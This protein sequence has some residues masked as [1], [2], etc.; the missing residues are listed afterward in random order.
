MDEALE[1]PIW[2]ALT[3]PQASHGRR[4]GDAACFARDVAPFAAIA[5]PH[6]RAYDDLARL[7]GDAPEA[8]LFRPL[9]EAVPEGWRATSEREIVQMVCEALPAPRR[10][11]P[12]PCIMPLGDADIPAMLDLAAVTHPGPF[13]SRTLELGRFV[14][15]AANGSLAAMAGERLRLPGLVELSAI[16]TRPAARGRGLARA[17]VRALAAAALA[18]GETPF[19]HVFPDNVP[20][21]GLY[22]ALGFAAR[23]GCWSAGWCRRR[24]VDV[25]R[26]ASAAGVTIANDLQL[27]DRRATALANGS[28][29]RAKRPRRSGRGS[30]GRRQALP[31]GRGV[32][33]LRRFPLAA[34]AP[35][36]SSLAPVN[37]ALLA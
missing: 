10:G 12:H 29:L 35:L 21:V 2:H 20:A 11:A 23:A 22:R 25:A 15:V 36:F 19:L 9:G 6:V 37:D 7:I 33:R 3:G 18:R 32:G 24:A 4:S 26:E 1:N 5:G 14:G 13:A 8:R 34:A 17:V 27:R 16:C 28:Q 30:A 31:T